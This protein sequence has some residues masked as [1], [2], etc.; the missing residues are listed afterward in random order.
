VGFLR[1]SSLRHPFQ[2]SR[3]IFFSDGDFDLFVGAADGTVLL[4]L[5]GDDG[6][7]A[8]A[9]ADVFGSASEAYLSAAG[10]GG[11]RSL[12]TAAGHKYTALPLALSG[13]ATVAV[14]AA[15]PFL[16]VPGLASAGASSWVLGTYAAPNCADLDGDRSPEKQ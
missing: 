11:L 7:L 8:E 9:A 15:F 2:L 10:G 6:S 13:L 5:A 14:G 3:R 16:L 4:R 1:F 12:R